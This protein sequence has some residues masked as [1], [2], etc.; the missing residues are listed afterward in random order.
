M[1]WQ[2]FHFWWHL[3]SKTKLTMKFSTHSGS[4][5]AALKNTPFK[6]FMDIVYLKKILHHKGHKVFSLTVFRMTYANCY[7]H[8]FKNNNCSKRLNVVLLA[9]LGK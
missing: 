4:S 9:P 5:Q 6:I 7:M 3:N 1:V 8:V 2:K